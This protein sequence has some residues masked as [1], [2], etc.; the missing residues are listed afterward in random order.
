V[1]TSTNGH[2]LDDDNARLLVES[3]IDRLI[4]SV[5]GSDQETYALYR[6]G[7]NLEVVKQGIRNVIEW[8]KKLKSTFPTVEMQFL[9][10]GTNEHQI[11]EVRLLAKTL[12]VDKL[13][14]KSAQLYS[15][16][17]NPFLTTFPGFSRYTSEDGY[18]IKIKS[19]Y[20]NSCH[21][22]WNSP[23][24]TWDGLIVPCC[25]DKDA[26]HILGDLKTSNFSDCWNSESYLS[27]RKDVFS[28]RSEIPI[29]RNCNEG[30]SKA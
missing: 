16:E 5:D 15:V 4:I 29:C 6:T 28:R 22:M 30:I 1:A 25:F 7:G 10:L 9:V 13:T 19:K 18:S 12:R 14:L 3:G 2:F 11:N 24:I 8:K 27:F 20:P 26:D 17:K 23:V 21:R